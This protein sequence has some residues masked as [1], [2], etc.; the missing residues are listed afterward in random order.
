[1]ELDARQRQYLKGLAH[2]LKPVVHIGKDGVSESVVKQ[3]DRALLDHELIKVKLAD[4]API[5]R[6]EASAEL[7]AKT[8]AAFIQNI[9]KVFVLYRQHPEEPRLELPPP[10]RL[11]DD[12]EGPRDD[13]STL[14]RSV[15]QRGAAPIERQ[16]PPDERNAP[17][18]EERP[19]Q[20]AP[21]KRASPA[22]GGAK[23]ERA[24]TNRGKRGSRRAK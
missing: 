14:L 17:R 3:I 19:A 2:H 22:R 24:P 9:G 7:P 10:R 1:M 4:G 16:A 23:R 13:E 6:K 12:G 5:D 21:A 8:G 18:R 20:R 11:E 15:R